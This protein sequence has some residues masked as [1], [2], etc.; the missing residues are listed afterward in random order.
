MCV[1]VGVDVDVDG[2]A[3]VRTMSSFYLPS[4][5]HAKE[6]GR[7]WGERERFPS[8]P[9]VL[10]IDLLYVGQE[11]ILISGVCPL[12]VQPKLSVSSWGS[13]RVKFL[14]LVGLHQNIR[15]AVSMY[16]WAG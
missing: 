9:T 11:N 13:E 2:C 15:S 14:M 3:H 7:G 16:Y 8:K 4:S 12:S 1:C 6:R 10:T 5:Y